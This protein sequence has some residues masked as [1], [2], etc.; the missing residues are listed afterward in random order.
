MTSA[1]IPS[2]G[3]RL[4][5][6]GRDLRAEGEITVS[7]ALTV[8]V[9]PESV[10]PNPAQSD[11][12]V[13]YLEPK[14][15][16]LSFDYLMRNKATEFF[17]GAG[18]RSVGNCV[19]TT[20]SE[21]TDGSTFQAAAAVTPG[22]VI[23]VELD[24]GEIFPTLVL[25]CT[26]TGDSPAKYDIVPLVALPS[27][28]S[29]GKRVIAYDTRVPGLPGEINNSFV[30]AAITYSNNAGVQLV[31]NTPWVSAIGDLTYEPGT[32]PKFSVTVGGSDYAV[33]TSGDTGYSTNNETGKAV[34]SY[35]DHEAVKVADRGYVIVANCDKDGK[36][37]GGTQCV[38]TATISFGVGAENI[39]GIG[40]SGAINGGQ[41]AMA[42]RERPT[43]SMSILWDV[44][45]LGEWDANTEKCVAIIQPTNDPTVP[46]WA[47]FAPRC[48]LA[49]APETD[50]SGGL[51]EMSL[52]FGAQPAGMDGSD[53]SRDH[54]L[55]QTFYF[56]TVWAAE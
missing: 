18:C 14:D 31:V 40:C 49:E 8:G 3:E 5:K 15:D 50:K 11:K 36:I 54:D 13:H 56:G 22:Q 53:G 48:W 1:A 35:L 7:S 41:G 12:P 24:S 32:L 21:Y 38:S 27:A 26:E 45:K 25:S 51:I 33:L 4:I 55:N 23:G 2:R 44:E 16:L 37:S 19:Q 10:Y 34:S 28:T 29:E 39:P 43:V 6:N 52:T 20:I 46:G 9:T 42:T 47:F 30:G 17:E